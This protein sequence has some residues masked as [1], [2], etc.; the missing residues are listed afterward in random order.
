M[1]DRG[2]AVHYENVCEQDLRAALG[3]GGR[4]NKNKR[5]RTSAAV[6]E[7]SEEEEPELT[8]FVHGG[9]LYLR[10]ACG[11]V[12]SSERDER[13][14]LV[15]VGT[16]DAVAGAFMPL[17]P[18]EP[19]AS[20]SGASSAP[21]GQ[22]ARPP[23]P[24]P[25]PL[26]FDADELDHCE[27]APEALALVGSARPSALYG[28]SGTLARGQ[29]NRNAPRATSTQAYAHIAPLL[30]ALATSLGTE[31]GGLRIYDPCVFWLKVAPAS[32][33]AAPRDPA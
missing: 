24:A 29:D 30:G 19:E 33:P 20:E 12:Y 6:A 28:R 2:S 15:A 17:P 25:D 21:A 32:A 27:T 5:K 31:A 7:E 13:C 16:W 3:M 1:E 26:T 8:G 18:V 11:A 22:P 10:S 9:E 23:A 14:R 4:K